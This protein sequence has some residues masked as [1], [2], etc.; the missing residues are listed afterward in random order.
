MFGLFKK[1]EF[2]QMP[3][4][5]RPILKLAFPGGEKQLN[6]ETKGLLEAFPDLFTLKSSQDLVVWTKIMWL[7]NSKSPENHLSFQDICEA[8]NRHE[9][10]RLT[11]EQCSAIYTKILE[12]DLETRN[13]FS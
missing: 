12:Q 10:N 4:D 3:K 6:Q 2:S 8:I 5:V 7:T 9:N 1:E 11:N 13:I